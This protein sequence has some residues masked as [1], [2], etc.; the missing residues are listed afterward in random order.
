MK[1]IIAIEEIITKEFEGEINS[2]EKPMKQPGR[3]TDLTSLF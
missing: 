3:N 1:Y 2:A